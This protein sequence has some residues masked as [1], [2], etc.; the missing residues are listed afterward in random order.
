MGSVCLRLAGM[1][2]LFLAA[3]TSASSMPPVHASP[4][5]VAPAQ[6]TAK[7]LVEQTVYNDLKDREDGT[8]WT[9]HVERTV[10]GLRKSEEEVET[11]EG[12]VYRIFAI[13]GRPLNAVEQRIEDQRVTTLLHDP[14]EQR[15]V[16]QQH[17]DD[18]ARVRRLMEMLPRAFL[19]EMD[20][21]DG[22]N[23]RLR[24]RPNPDFEPPNIEGRIFHAL[25]GTMLI[26]AQQKRVA[27]I[28]GQL[29]DDVEFGFGLLGRINKGGVFEIARQPVSS[30]HWKTDRVD[31]HVN[32]HIILFKTVSK[33]QDEVRSNFRQVPGDLT[34]PQAFELLQSK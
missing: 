17:E 18:E 31:V 1:L 7:D 22:D 15:R 29:I 8:F 24:F 20:G 28:K 33:Q 2:P 25:A 10:E 21:M 16:K 9:Y 26:N 4:L 6:E 23:V 14:A 32:G 5:R 11:R 19:Y 27:D 30:T 13:N 3:A 12:P 34:V